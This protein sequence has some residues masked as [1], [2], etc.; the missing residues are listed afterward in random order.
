MP[1]A[2]A[3]YC[4]NILWCNS[5]MLIFVLNVNLNCYIGR[6]FDSLDGLLVEN[7]GSLKR[8][9]ILKS[10]KEIYLNPFTQHEQPLGLTDT[11]PQ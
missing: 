8:C 9:C 4:T 1:V 6:L 10:K 2:G 7:I 3:P 11:L 5:W